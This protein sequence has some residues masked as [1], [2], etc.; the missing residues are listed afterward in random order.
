MR[1][2][3][4]ILTLFATAI[5]IAVLARFNPGNVVLFYPPYRVDMSL[6]FF[7]VVLVL[8][9]V[10]LLA[11]V[12][13]VRATM[14]LP[15]R[16][17]EYRAMRQLRESGRALHDALRSYLEGR[18][19]RAEKSAARAAESPEFAGLAALIGARAAQRV[20]EPARRDKWLATAAD[21]ASVRTARLMSTVELL[22]EDN[23]EAEA[24][25]A[26]LHELNANGIRHAQALRL[27]LK[28]NQNNRNWPEVL[29]LVKLLDKHQALHPSLS[30]R[31]RDLAYEALLP[32][33]A[34]D[35][36][37]LRKL[38]STVPGADR[39]SP[40]V[41]ALAANAFVAAGRPQDAAEILEQ[42]LAAQWDVRLLRAYRQCAA[43]EGSAALL[44][45]IEQAE[46][47]LR[48]RPNDAELSL[49]LGALCQRQKLWGKAQRHLE[50][51]ALGAADRVTL[52]E[53]HL[54]LAQ[55]HESLGQLETA[56]THFRECALTTQPAQ[57]GQSAARGA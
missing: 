22:S 31:L 11:I 1:F 10:L 2:F 17:A 16:V 28:V 23:K 18:F 4:W 53:A 27:A 47:W 57:P 30:R 8:V 3:L 12:N 9:F 55:M 46:H 39:L 48:E 42:A 52:Q 19:G 37:A 24:A 44:A 51:A 34:N 35:L 56:A 26:A 7:A 38:W 25:Q 45:Q 54:R 36:E 33:A 5:G 50:Q 49:L 13:A 43:P 14:A 41:A 21:D 20:Q 32:R 6:N 40:A 15:R 29:R